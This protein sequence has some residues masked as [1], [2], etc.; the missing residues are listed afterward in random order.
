[1]W[2]GLSVS[3]RCTLASCPYIVLSLF[4][5]RYTN[6]ISKLNFT[7]SQNMSYTDTASSLSGHSLIC[8]N[9]AHLVLWCYL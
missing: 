3:T 1:M 4:F 9:F 6:E 2:S 7:A 5:F 8:L